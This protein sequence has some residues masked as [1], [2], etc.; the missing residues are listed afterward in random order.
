MFT[1]YIK[2]HLKCVMERVQ[3]QNQIRGL[4]ATVA[5]FQKYD[6]HFWHANKIC[7]CLN[8]ALIFC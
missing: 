1:F 3:Q 4:L 8:N 5:S 7:H 6:A 2:N